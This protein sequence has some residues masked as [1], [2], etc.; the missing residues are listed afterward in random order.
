MCEANVYLVSQGKEQELMKEVL[1][2]E[3]HD[4][5][6]LLTDFLGEQKKVRAKIKNIDFGEHKVFLEET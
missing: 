3:V 6:L 4:D 2:L 5:H 1:G